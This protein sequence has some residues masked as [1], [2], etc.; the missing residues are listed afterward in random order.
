MCQAKC[1]WWI[2]SLPAVPYFSWVYDTYQAVT[3][4]TPG[5]PALKS[6]DPIQA[7]HLLLLH[8]PPP[9][10]ARRSNWIFWLQI[11][12]IKG[13]EE[14]GSSLSSNHKPD[15]NMTSACAKEAVSARLRA[16]RL[17]SK[18]NTWGGSRNSY[19]SLSKAEQNTGIKEQ[20]NEGVIL[21]ITNR[22]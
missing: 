16:C 12:H 8:Q 4:K 10:C 13:G 21:S 6:I 14:L 1:P 22:W 18:A 19:L 20:I 15:A 3:G 5:S 9:E 7:V 2:P 11:H 17:T